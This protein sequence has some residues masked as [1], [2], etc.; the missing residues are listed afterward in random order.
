MAIL[1]LYKLSYYEKTFVTKDVTNFNYIS[2]SAIWEFI[3][4]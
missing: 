3:A 4:Y 2:T 1:F